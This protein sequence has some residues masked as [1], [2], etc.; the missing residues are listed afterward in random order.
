M[1]RASWQCVRD[2]LGRQ[3]MLWGGICRLTQCWKKLRRHVVLSHTNDHLVLL[4]S[5]QQQEATVNEVIFC[6]DRS[7]IIDL[8]I[9]HPESASLDEASSSTLAGLDARRHCHI[10]QSLPHHLVAGESG[11]R[12]LLSNGLQRSRIQFRFGSR[13]QSLGGGER[14]GEAGLPVHEAG[15]LLRQPSLRLVGLRPWLPHLLLDSSDLIE[16]EEGEHAQELGDL[17]VRYVSQQ[18]LVELEGRQ[19]VSGEPDSTILGLAELAAIRL[20]EQREGEAEAQLP[21]LPLLTCHLPHQLRARG[22]VA[23]L[24]AAACLH[25]HTVPPVQVHEVCTLQELVAE[26]GKA[27]AL[28]GL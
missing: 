13:L 14:L 22:D 23:P 18:M 16:G 2:T 17:R 21:V 9:V 20:G 6:N 27:D 4:A 19:L 12:G 24:V 5:S 7:F 10:S 3:D 26:L 8:A 25:A 15:H 28:R 11:G 1:S